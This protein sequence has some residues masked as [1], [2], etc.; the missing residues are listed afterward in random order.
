MVRPKD[1]Q[2]ELRAKGPKTRCTSY[3]CKGNNAENGDKRVIGYLD[4]MPIISFLIIF[5]IIHKRIFC[6]G[7]QQ[8]IYITDVIQNFFK[9]DVIIWLIHILG[10]Y[11]FLPKDVR[12]LPGIHPLSNLQIYWLPFP[13][14]SES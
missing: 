8:K 4:K 9:N 6:R 10:S 12:N 13:A 7:F 11:R 2:D 3:S 14:G 5:K 1:P